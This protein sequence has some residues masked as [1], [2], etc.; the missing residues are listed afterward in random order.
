MGLLVLARL[1]G[2]KPCLLSL[3]CLAALMV[4]LPPLAA[5]S[6]GWQVVVRLIL[7]RWGQHAQQ[8]QRQWWV[9][10]AALISYVHGGPGS[11][12]GAAVVT[13]P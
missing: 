7:G 4:S 1:R 12:E 2:Q 8:A 10:L 13:K 11:V 9:T 5:F 3:Q 6:G